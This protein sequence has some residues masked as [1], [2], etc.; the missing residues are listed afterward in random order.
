MLVA[1]SRLART[2]LGWE[3]RFPDLEEMIS[4]AWRWEQR[5]TGAAEVIH[6]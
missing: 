5:H 1:E 3:P 2:R 6:A 4:T